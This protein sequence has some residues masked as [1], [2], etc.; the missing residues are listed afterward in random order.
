MLQLVLFGTFVTLIGCDLEKQPR[1]LFF[2][3]GNKLCDFDCKEGYIYKQ[4]L[5]IFVFFAFTLVLEFFS[6]EN[7]FYFR[8]VIYHYYCVILLLPP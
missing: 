8:W 1:D 6:K 7:I 5:F 2:L 4:H 3:E